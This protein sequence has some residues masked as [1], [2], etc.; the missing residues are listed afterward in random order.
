[1]AELMNLNMMSGMAHNDLQ[2]L[3]ACSAQ[4]LQP[5][6]AAGLVCA[7]C[8]QRQRNCAAKNPGATEPRKIGT[9]STASQAERRGLL[10]I[11]RR[12]SNKFHRRLMYQS[13][14]S[15]VP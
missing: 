2:L 12:S 14:A 10:L 6:T 9:V 3:H 8:L 5:R 4:E 15:P 11:C 1:M 13:W 7:G